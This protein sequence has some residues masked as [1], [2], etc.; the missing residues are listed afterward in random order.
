MTARKFTKKK[1][2]SRVSFGVILYVYTNVNNRARARAGYCKQ[3]RR[4]S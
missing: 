3:R 1:Q 4:F 2:Q